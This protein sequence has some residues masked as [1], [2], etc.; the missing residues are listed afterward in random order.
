MDPGIPITWNEALSGVFGSISIA[1]WIFLLVPQLIT[2]Y[3]HSSASGLSLA[4]LLVWL[5]GDITSFV[6]SLLAHL[7]PTVVLLGGY[8]CVADFVLIT[9]V[10]YYNFINARREAKKPSAAHANANGHTADNEESPL[11]RRDSAEAAH[12][13]RRRKSSTAS[14]RSTLSRRYSRGSLPSILEESTGTTAWLK[15]TGAIIGICAVGAAGWGIAYGTGVWKPVPSPSAV[16]ASRMGKEASM[17]TAASVLGYA[18]AVCYLGAR[19]P[20]IVKNQRE[21]S[22][23]GLSLLFFCLSLLGNATYGAGILFHSLEK[24]Y[25]VKNLPWLLGS[26]GTIVEDVVI[27]VQFHAF[28]DRPPPSAI[29]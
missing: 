5:L 18:S 22:C 10:L 17:Q 7:V 23:E 15:N 29:V 28:R 26:L 14:R 27:F 2:N 6:G 12:Q 16:H 21:K 11:L 8:F 24:D 20:Q 19:I 4:F 1:A 25:V 3:T 13:P 9:Q